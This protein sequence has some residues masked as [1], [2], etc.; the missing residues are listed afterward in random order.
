MRD[1][2]DIE[3]VLRITGLGIHA[4]QADGG[5]DF[6]VACNIA[7]KKIRKAK[8]YEDLEEQGRLLKLP[9]AV[10]D[11]VYVIN[12][13]NNTVSEEKVYDIQYRGEKYKKGQRIFMNIGALAYFEMDFGKTVF[14]TKEEA[15]QAIGKE[16]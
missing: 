3:Q 16:N 5:A 10:G 15:E 6:D 8:E 11:I 1:R 13:K 12:N 9:C 4:D 7:V 14:L 2:F